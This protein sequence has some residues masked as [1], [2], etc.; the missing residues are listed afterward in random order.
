MRRTWEKE[1]L[2]QLCNRS[3]RTTT[4]LDLLCHFLQVIDNSLAFIQALNLLRE[5]GDANSFPNHNLSF[6]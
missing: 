2:Q 4:G 6:S 3:R 5:I 1:L